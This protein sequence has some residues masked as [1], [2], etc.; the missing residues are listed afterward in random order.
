MEALVYEVRQQPEGCYS[1]EELL[2][3]W[4]GNLYKGWLKVTDD[5]G[6]LDKLKYRKE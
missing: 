2:K 4:T 5:N 3:V 1:E 6:Q